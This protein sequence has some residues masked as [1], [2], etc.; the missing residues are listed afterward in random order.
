MSQFVHIASERLEP[1]ELQALTRELASSINRNTEVHAE[2]PDGEAGPGDRGDPV[3][4]GAI[5]LGFI[6][7]GAAVAL[8][9]VMKAYLERDKSLTMVFERSD[10]NKLMIEAENLSANRID[11]SVAL[12]EAFFAN[13]DAGVAQ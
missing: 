3:T 10:G 6:S 9:E 8:F 5:V 13:S 12:A 11:K 7:S 1:T 4:L 2:L